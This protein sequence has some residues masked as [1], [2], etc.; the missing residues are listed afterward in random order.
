MYGNLW[1]GGLY[2]IK[3]LY[4]IDCGRV[5]FR[6]NSENGEISHLE[7]ATTSTIIFYLVHLIFYCNKNPRR[8]HDSNQRPIVKRN[9][10]L[11]SVI[12]FPRCQRHY[13]NHLELTIVA[14]IILY[15]GRYL[16]DI[17]PAWVAYTVVVRINQTNVGIKSNFRFYLTFVYNYIACVSCS[18]KLLGFIIS[19]PSRVSTINYNTYIIQPVQC[20]DPVQREFNAP[21]AKI[22]TRMSYVNYY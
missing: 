13:R 7:M 8:S 11:F 5:L 6:S 17:L 16:L 21:S 22:N 12:Y 3:N 2:Y 14:I 19:L 9:T 1:C 10:G 20:T 4:H 15:L 18:I